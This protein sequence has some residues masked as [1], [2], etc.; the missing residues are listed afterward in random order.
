VADL[1]LAIE[2]IEEVFSEDIPKGKIISSQPGGGGK[3][4]P[5]GV[6]GLIISKGQE[7][8]EIPNLEGLTPDIA[9]QKIGELGLTAGDINEIFDMKI[10]KGNVIRTDPKAGEKVKRKAIVNLDVSKGIEK[11]GLVSYVGKGG[12]EALSELT[13]SG[14]DVNV[15]YKFSDNIFKGQV[16]SQS[17]DKSDSI[18]LGSKVDLV[19]SKGPE[20]VFVPNVLG[21]SKNDASLDLENLGLRVTIK[22]SGKVNNISP[23]IGT[24]VKQGAV[25][26]LTLR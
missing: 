4:S 5:G 19:V 10:E 12:D 16:I 20:F 15:S 11:V 6:V 13:N 17:P 2:V 9:L 22:G 8:I 24:K 3:V 1:G 26:T 23:N 7:R 18:D 14:F 21:K 25:I